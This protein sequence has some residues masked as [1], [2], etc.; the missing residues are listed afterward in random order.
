M[1]MVRTSS[2]PR[3]K[4]VLTVTNV[5]KKEDIRGKELPSISKAASGVSTMIAI[6]SKILPA[7]VVT[8]KTF[9]TWNKKYHEN[10][11]ISKKK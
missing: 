10:A 2:N 1:D 7:M 6:V 4:N 8:K 3:P 11:L 5:M 9:T